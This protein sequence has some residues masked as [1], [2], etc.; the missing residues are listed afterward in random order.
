VTVRS[1]SVDGSR[2]P[3]VVIVGME[4]LGLCN[5]LQVAQHH[6]DRAFMTVHVT[7]ERAWH[8]YGDGPAWVERLGGQEKFIAPLRRK[9]RELQRK[10]IAD[11]NSAIVGNA[12]Q[13]ALAQ[14]V[15][16]ALAN[17]AQ[18]ARFIQAFF[19]RR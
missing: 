18:Q 13:A 8:A 15:N 16:M 19:G 5:F 12:L 11:R 17:Q 2:A 6:Y 3:V 4:I 9:L 1:M 10:A 7:P 14:S